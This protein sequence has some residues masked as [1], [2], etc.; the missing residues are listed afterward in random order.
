MLAFYLYVLI[1]KS[2][3]K[4]NDTM[5]TTFFTDDNSL[6]S[7][8]EKVTNFTAFAVETATGLRSSL[9]ELSFVKVNNGVIVEK[10]STLVQPPY[11]DYDE[12]NIRAHGIIPQMT[13][14]LPLFPMVWKK[15]KSYFE[16]EVVVAYCTEFDI[17]AL[18]QTLEIY[19]QEVPHFNFSCTY[20][21]FGCTIDEACKKHDIYIEMKNKLSEAEACAKLFLLNQGIKIYEKRNIRIEDL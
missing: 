11:N 16:K 5:D 1:L 13:E 12:A 14:N 2:N 6:S 17:D 9:C 8:N 4:I 19:Q 21:L 7:L 15:I 20:N 18:T 10:Y 3:P